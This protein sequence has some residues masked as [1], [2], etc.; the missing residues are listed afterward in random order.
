MGHDTN[1]DMPI[2]LVLLAAEPVSADPTELSA[3]LRYAVRD[4]YAVTLHF[5][6]NGVSPAVTWTF[7]RQLLLT[8]LRVH[9]GEGDV[10]IWPAH[11]RPDHTYIQL[12]AP[13]GRALFAAAT[14]DLQLFLDTTIALV[15]EGAEADQVDMDAELDA[16]LG[17]VS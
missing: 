1:V 3:A 4:P 15:A 14:Q 9:A 7:D 8:G 16:L 10:R 5:P 13:S 2:E 6:A 11:D 12:S 17:P